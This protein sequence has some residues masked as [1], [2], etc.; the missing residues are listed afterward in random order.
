MVR[1][2]GVAVPCERN[3]IGIIKVGPLQ[4]VPVT[5]EITILYLPRWTSSSGGASGRSG[6]ILKCGTQR[7]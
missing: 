7:T 2:E 3:L 1:P 6:G 5:T 4:I